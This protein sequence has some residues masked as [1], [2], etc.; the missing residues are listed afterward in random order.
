MQIMRILLLS[1]FLLLV[2]QINCQIVNT[3][4]GQ[5]EG[6]TI[7]NVYRFLGVPYAKPPIGNLRWKPPVAPDSWSGIRSATSYADCCPYCDRGIPDDIIQGNEDCLYLNIWSPNL[8]GSLPV[9]FYIHGGANQEGCSKD[10][11]FDGKN[12]A[13][14]GN[15]VVVSINYRIGP[16]G[17]LV[18]PG[19]EIENS[20]NSSGNYGILD[21]IMALQW[22]KNNI[23]NFGGD[24][25]K[26]MIFGCSAGGLD[27]GTLILSP[28]ANN[29]FHRAAMQSPAPGF[30]EYQDLKNYSINYINGY[31]NNG[32]D[33]DK[34]AYA[35]T[36]PVDSLLWN[37]G[38]S[39][40]DAVVTT[41]W[42]PVNDGYVLPSNLI[43]A[44][45]MGNFNHV[46]LIIGSTANEI[47]PVLGTD[48]T[49]AHV[50]DLINNFVPQQYIPLALQL[51]PPG[52][53]NVEARESLIKM[54]ADVQFTAPARRFARC[55]D[56]NQDQPVWRYFLTY[57]SASH[58][59]DQYFI[60]NT[61]ENFVTPPYFTLQDDSMQE[62]MLN[63]WV[64]FANTGNPNGQ[65]LVNWP[66]LD[67]LN[68]C[69]LEIKATPDGS[70]CGIRTAECN[71]WDS[72]VG[73]TGCSPIIDE[74]IEDNLYNDF[75]I[76]PNPTDGIVYFR[77]NMN[78]DYNVYINDP[79]GRVLAT[80]HNPPYIDLFNLSDGVYYFTIIS[81]QQRIIKKIIL[82]R[83]N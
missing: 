82:Q 61:Y 56:E 4:Y 71:L 45:Q 81:N 54:L 3:Q 74:I 75:S 66:E 10:P 8:T 53:N 77:Y 16:L 60:F 37:M 72:V 55:I 58:G 47:G 1:V 26:V 5:I 48:I 25:N 24:P 34:I 50:I 44:I 76:F 63:Y 2:Q 9:M 30:F 52:N 21:Q 33:A 46:P 64:N 39:I 80:Y 19:L 18:H 36:L 79:M 35:R 57:G 14:R 69:Y 28:L 65:D 68:D 40:T 38:P 6:M 51:Y 31:I 42:G 73:F 70:N 17:F 29:L 12:L 78:D 15:V 59:M 13:E 83:K 23:S 41:N 22:V 27:V 7:D 49:P 62:N 67:A 11:I 20:Y 43:E 32:T